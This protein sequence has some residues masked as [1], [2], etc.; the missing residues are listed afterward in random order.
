MV[1]TINRDIIKDIAENFKKEMPSYS[2]EDILL[3]KRDHNIFK[4]I[5]SKFA[6]TKIKMYPSVVYRIVHFNNSFKSYFHNSESHDS[7]RKKNNIKDIN[8]K[9]LLTTIQLNPQ[10]SLNYRK[11]KSVYGISCV[12]IS[13]K[14]TLNNRYQCYRMWHKIIKEELKNIHVFNNEIENTS[15]PCTVVSPEN[16][17]QGNSNNLKEIINEELQMDNDSF[18]Q[19]FNIPNII[20]STPQKTVFSNES[21]SNENKEVQDLFRESPDRFNLSKETLDVPV[22]ILNVSDDHES[23]G[24][25]EL[26]PPN[27]RN[28]SRDILSNAKYKNCTV[29]EGTFEIPPNIWSQIFKNGKLHTKYYPFYFRN[30]INKYINNICQ[31]VF[32]YVKYLKKMIINIYAKCIHSQCKKFKIVVNDRKVFVYSTSINYYHKKCVTS[33]LKGVER[34]IVK[35][36]IL[37]KKPLAYKKEIIRRENINFISKTKNLRKIKSDATFRKIKSEAKSEK[38]RDKNE[39]LD[40]IKMQEDH[41]EY[42]KE[43]SFPFNVKLYSKEQLTILEK[44]KLGTVLPYIYFDATGKL[45]RNPGENKKTVLFYTGVVSVHKIQRTLP[46][47]S[48]ISSSH[49]AHSI[50]KLL[51]DFRYFCEENRKWPVLAGVVT[52][53]SFANIHAISKAFNRIT[54]VEYLDVCMTTVSKD[55]LTTTAKKDFITIHLCCAHFLKMAT[56]DINLLSKN[57]KQKLLF[58]DI[59]AAAVK[60]K[61]LDQLDKWF[62]NAVILLSG[63]YFNRDIKKSLNCLKELCCKDNLDDEE[64]VLSSNTVSYF[65]ND[66]RLYTKSPF[67]KRYKNIYENTIISNEMDRENDYENKKLLMLIL[68]KYMP[69]SPLW[70]GMMLVE[71]ERISNAVV[72][73]YFGDLKRNILN[74]EKNL[75]CSRFVRLYRE[76]IISLYK[77]CQLDIEKNKLT[78]KRS[79]PTH[80]DHTEEIYSQE[81]WNKKT[82]TVD[83]HFTA[84]YIKH[85]SVSLVSDEN[86]RDTKQL[87]KDKS[88]IIELDDVTRCV[89]CGLV[90][91]NETTLFVQCDKCDQWVHQ[92]CESED[93][94]FT[95][96]FICKLCTNNFNDSDAP[97]NDLFQKCASFIQKISL[98]DDEKRYLEIRTVNQHESLEWKEQRRIRI[99]ASFFG[100]ICKARESSYE[101]IVKDITEPKYFNI[102]AINH[103]QFYESVARNEYCKKNNVVCLRSGLLIHKM[104]PFIAASPDGLINDKGVIEIKCPYKYRYDNPYDVQFDFLHKDNTIKI[105]HNYH[106][107]IQGLLEV[108]S[109]E[110]CDLV[111]Y[112]FSDIKCIR[113]Q[114]NRSFWENKMLPILKKFYYFY[115]L[116]YIV[117]PKD[118]LSLEDK[119]WRTVKDIQF[120]ENGLVNDITYYRSLKNK[121][122]Y[123]VSY[124]KNATCPIKEIIIADYL[125]LDPKEY[126]SSFIVDI[127]F[128]L[129]NKKTYFQIIST[130]KSS[131]IFS[132]VSNLE[133]LIDK[134]KIEKNNIIM[135]IANNQHYVLAVINIK[136]KTFNLIDPLGSSVFKT[137]KYL[138]KFIFFLN[139]V[140]QRH[141]QS[142]DVKN[143]NPVNIDHLLQDDSYN[144][145]LYIIY[146]F[147]NI[148][149]NKSLKTYKNMDVFRNEIKSMLLEKSSNIKDKCIYCNE[150]VKD[151]YFKCN[152]CL[153]FSHTKCILSADEIS[154]NIKP[155]S[156]YKNNLCELCYNY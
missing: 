138:D 149:E 63:K 131:F 126:L 27:S 132:D 89:Y 142:F 150:D 21:V 127:C 118:Y 14:N 68:N 116:P 49:D 25:V 11:K 12:T 90:K 115:I 121:R 24:V 57:E 139:L 45:V 117:C 71:R 47:F 6:N 145:G 10:M 108:L 124:F 96:Q 106:Y 17:N 120:L 28:L 9:S 42:I 66:D 55:L 155:A 109:R 29:L 5:S 91:F 110:W 31:I 88:N 113:V 73:N 67:Y 62:K 35:K 38:D 134:T 147:Q 7:N 152:M 70:N 56:K 77:E 98:T 44:Q 128:N 140:N 105:S 103:G 53:F 34:Y 58:K 59:L 46:I 125:T 8:L 133:Y 81:S 32:K 39:K 85:L 64:N 50:F 100:R 84:R 22:S 23:K 154:N 95:G 114:R 112:T 86:E 148:C 36:N 65:D 41:P 94:S 54:L 30:R 72:E 18:S 78:T 111:I 75:K 99:T 135:P 130:E 43:V 122:G 151:N 146:F 143:W 104:F 92:T 3:I 26:L 136:D 69:Y 93:T 20:T 2:L 87:E 119:K 101:N 52:D 79:K 60:I 13:K 144:C 156:K 83:T 107:Q 37:N 4:H 40:I 33:Y 141:K 15:L 97:S 1:K 129:I 153:R 80:T 82:K 74:G 102:D 123:T 48:M 16:S 137:K 76:E 51:D 61:K 19:N